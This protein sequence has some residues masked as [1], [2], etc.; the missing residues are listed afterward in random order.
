VTPEE[1]LNLLPEVFQRTAIGDDDPLT[2]LIEVMSVLHAP[3]E[4]VLAGLDSYF[5]PRRCPDGFVPYLSR[6][7]DMAWTF[8]DPPD[9]P[10]ATPGRP[11]AG[12]A[13]T[14]GELVARAAVE[15]RWQ[16]TAGGLVRM[17]EAATGVTGFAVDEAVLDEFGQVR[18]FFI[19]VHGPKAAQPL[20]GLVQR[21]AEH[22]K[23]AHVILDGEIAW[24]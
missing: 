9:D 14:L 1:I 23:P 20:E 18:P 22:E 10:Y 8:L 5:D 4:A 13:G 17:L 21:I 15:C 2:A 6:W 11:F 3:D 7:V 19:R 16:G 24:A 12:G